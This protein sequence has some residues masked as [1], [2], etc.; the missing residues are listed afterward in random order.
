MAMIVEIVE[1]K[2]RKND[3]KRIRKVITVG[4]FELNQIYC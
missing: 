2:Q 1:R 4:V 3:A